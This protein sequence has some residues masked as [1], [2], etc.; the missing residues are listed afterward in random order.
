[1]PEM[2][3]IKMKDGDAVKRIPHNVLRHF[4]IIPRLQRLFHDV[5]T[6]EDVLW[7][8]RNKEYRDQNVMSRPSHE[9]EWQSFNQKH[10]KF[11]PDPRNIRLGLASDGFKPFGHQS[12]TYSMWPVL[13]TLTTCLQMSAPKNQTT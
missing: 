1:M 6:R 13:V 12:A 9:S 2:Q 3:I 11:A 7:H 4:P 5:E 8:S 10:K